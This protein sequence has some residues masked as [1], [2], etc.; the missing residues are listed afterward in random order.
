MGRAQAVLG[1]VFMEFSQFQTSLALTGKC[2]GEF[3]HPGRNCLVLSCVSLPWS[4]DQVISVP[5]LHPTALKGGPCQQV[6]FQNIWC[7]WVGLG[8]D[9]LKGSFSALVVQR[10]YGMADSGTALCHQ[11]EGSIYTRAFSTC[12][13]GTVKKHSLS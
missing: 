2:T 13:F 6:F 8:L 1:L 7:C 4:R 12:I 5:E 9:D 3:L 11:I 10:P